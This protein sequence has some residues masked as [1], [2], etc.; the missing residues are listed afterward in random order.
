MKNL[1]S[2][3]VSCKFCLYHTY[4]FSPQ[5]FS[6]LLNRLQ[7]KCDQR[8]QSPCHH[9]IS[10]ILLCFHFLLSWGSSSG[11][12]GT[13]CWCSTSYQDRSTSPNI[14]DEAPNVD[15]VQGLFRQ[16]QSERVNIYTR[17]FNEGIHLISPDL[18]ASPHHH[19]GWRSSRCRWALRRRPLYRQVLGWCCWHWMLV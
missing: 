14:A 10:Q 18:H 17:W 11:G 2:F 5:E 1:F 16:A 19:A 3:Y 7:K 13:S 12:N 4:F 15:I 6:F 9:Q 8:D